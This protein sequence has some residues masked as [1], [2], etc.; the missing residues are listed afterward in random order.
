M[1]NKFSRVVAVLLA[2]FLVF[3]NFGAATA[4]A[5]D[6]ATGEKVLTVTPDMTGENGIL[7]VSGTWDRIIVPKEIDAS[8]IR[9]KE[10]KAGSVEIESGLSG[11]IELV[12][13]S[14][15]ALT[16]LPAKLT[17]MTVTDVINMIKETND[18]QAA[19]DLYFET[20]NK[21][22]AYLS[23]RPT[24]VAKNDMEISD[25]TLSGNVKLNL[26]N[27]K[28]DN[29]KVDADGS[30]NVLDVTISNF[31]GNVTVKQTGNE[32]G[33]YSLSR[34]KFKN[35]AIDTLVMDGD[36]KGNVVLEGQ[37]TNVGE[38]Q[39][40]NSS[41]VSLNLPTETVTVSETAT[42]VDLTVLNK[43]DEMKVSAA[44][45][46]VEV[47][48]CGTVTN[49]TVDGE[50]VTVSGNGVLT[51]VEITGE[52]VA[53]ST[54][55]T[56][57]EGENAY[58][59]PVVVP[60]KPSG[61]AAPGERDLGGLELVMVGW[62]E[63]Y[64]GSPESEALQAYR[65]EMMQK[66]NFTVKYVQTSDLIVDCYDIGP[67]LETAYALGSPIGHVFLMDCW[68]GSNSPLRDRAHLFYNLATLSELDFTEDKWNSTVTDLMTFKNGIYGMAINNDM[69][70]P[71][72]TAE[73][74]GVVYNKRLFEAAGL[75]PELPYTLQANGEWTWSKFKEL[76]EQ[77]TMDI[78]ED[79]VTD[80]YA[81]CN[82]PDYL[83]SQLV[84]SAGGQ[85]IDVKNGR[86]V[87]TLA[88]DEVLSALTYVNE[89]YDAGYDNYGYDENY[90]W[91]DPNVVFQAGA[92]AMQFASSSITYQLPG[93]E[94]S[95]GFVCCPK[96]D[97]ASSYQIKAEP[98]CVAVI[99]AFYDAK[100]ASDIAFAY[101]LWTN[102]APESEENE[103]AWKS[104][105]W[106]WNIDN[107][108]IEETFSLY[109]EKDLGIAPY[110]LLSDAWAGG[111][112]SDFWYALDEG[113][114][115]SEILQMSHL[116][117]EYDGYVT[118]LNTASAPRVT[119]NPTPYT[120][121]YTLRLNSD[122]TLT[123]TGCTNRDITEVV[124]P[125]KINGKTVTAIGESAFSDFYSLTSVTLPN[126]LRSIGDDA[127]SWCT[128][129]DNVV[130]PEG[131]TSIGLGAFN[132]CSS[133]ETITLP[134]TLKDIGNFAFGY[135]QMLDK[136]VIPEGVSSIKWQTF[137]GCYSL[138]NITIPK[139]ATSIEGMSFY[140]CSM[141]E[142]LVIPE[143]VLTIEDIPFEGCYALK[144][145]TIPSSAT[146]I[147]DE[148]FRD[149]SSDLILTVAE[150]SYAEQYARE[151]NYNVKYSTPVRDLG[152]MNIVIGD[153]QSTNWTDEMPY[154]EEMEALQTYR[155]AIM[156]K[157]NF[158]I[159]QKEVSIYGDIS[160]DFRTA[161]ESGTPEAQVYLLHSGALAGNMD[162]FYDL[163]TL[164]EL[165]FDEEKWYDTITEFMSYGGGIYG[166][167]PTTGINAWQNY[168]NYTSV[169]GVVF[170]KQ[171]L[172]DAGIDPDLPYDL[173]ASGQWTWSAFEE[174]CAKLTRDTDGDG[175]T[176]VYAS[177]YST[178]DYL[179]QLIFSTGEQLIE[180][181]ANGNFVNNTDSEKIKDALEYA[182]ALY[183][184]G[185]IRPQGED[186][187]WDYFNSAFLNKQVA[188]L[189]TGAY[190]PAQ[191]A[192]ADMEDELG[193][194][195]CPKPD[196]A[197]SY[198][199]MVSPT[200]AVIPACYDAETAA[201]IAFAYSL[202]AN[203]A[204]GYE[205]ETYENSNLDDR[206]INETFAL[207]ENSV[208]TV[209][210]T[211]LLD[212]LGYVGMDLYYLFPFD[213]LTLDE[214][215]DT[216][217]SKYDE[218]V[219]DANN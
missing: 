162:L 91:I 171:L 138:K 87:N 32:D 206:A 13:G 124:I 75:D 194:V 157:Y 161:V 12:S 188:M 37:K 184:A 113:R 159:T 17:T 7:T 187:N 58:V 116:L 192:F 78:N 95:I 24:I 106:D 119:V 97:G 14:I 137:M 34:I 146:S 151:H 129:L 59:P 65:E 28:V 53:V 212:E 86:F 22:D 203:P 101:N 63:S 31:N 147:S 186:E 4:Y 73:L 166:M 89:L 96:P 134:N 45:T 16:V 169:Y 103:D 94:D 126:T 195:C 199:F 165:N 11:K 71:I 92:A 128:M 202:W 41:S 72:P 182:V 208:G 131:V 54:P 77:L 191:G 185:Y 49:A 64:D 174:L 9:F 79:G 117:E 135:C 180:V 175:T 123:V 153:W 122:G 204:P 15:G 38:V 1:R 5:A 62:N 218:L 27:G 127:F 130:V 93:M 18:T 120:L 170:N 121:P 90:N 207:Y 69:D 150:N 214:C 20:R 200:V 25:V 149:C 2:L 99:P 163:S 102:P 144:D 74:Y 215:L 36:G 61:G 176:D 56:K 48:N 66:H 52:N 219:A 33:N 143:G 112:C 104:L 105:Y 85:F 168:G 60:N 44:E 57:V 160:E 213:I 210:Y 178:A 42:N 10:V 39:V 142:S 26:G 40:E 181:D 111:T 84:V 209:A 68:S 190:A 179:Q 133:L 139:S 164:S 107:K 125:S 145:I 70:A 197:D 148:A 196:Y 76:C 158:T 115:P 152:G 141:L 3:G 167:L 21:N 35:S 189:F 155:N 8:T 80:I 216:L 55:N 217:N 109:Y 47:G 51:D 98:S 110:S 172:I 23:K 154:S 46:K 118:A 30:Q 100:T 81:M 136:V 211:Y 83:I 198:Q 6:N 88:S 177:A 82:D 140:G 50:N 156:K 29:V 19:M 183:N 108:A 201:D 205:E 132:N 43:V 114:T 67:A 173:Q 193:F